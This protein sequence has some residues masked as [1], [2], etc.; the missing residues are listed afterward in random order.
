MAALGMEMDA[1]E[2]HDVLLIVRDGSIRVLRPMV[3][4]REP[5]RFGEQ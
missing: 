1:P 2:R 5:G 3:P 4:E